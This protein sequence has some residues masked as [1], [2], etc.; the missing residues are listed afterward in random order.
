[1]RQRFEQQ[2]TIGITP[3]SEVKISTKS[4]DELPPVL[5][6]LQYI[7]ATP[8]LNESIFNLL[9]DKVCSGKKKTGRPGMDLWH[10]LV[11][12]VVRHATGTNWDKLEDWSNNHTSL[13]KILGVHVE[14]FGIEEMEFNYQTI[15]DNVGM[16]D[17]ELLQ[18]INTL[19]ATHGQDLLKKKDEGPFFELKTDSFVVE[20]DVHFPT[21]LHLLWDS[22][23]KGLDMVE[24]LQKIAPIEG[25][26]E[27]KA[28]RKKLKSSF[29][30]T[31]Q[32]VFKGKDA[33]KKKEAVKGYLSMA[34][35]LKERCQAIIK[36]PP[37]N[38]GVSKIV[39]FLKT[40]CDYAEKF[41]D[42]IERRLIKGE[43]IPADE[44][45]FSIFEPYTEWLTKGKLHKEVEL[46]LLVMIT[47]TQN[48][49]IIDYK[50][51][52]K[53]RDQAQVAPLL[54]RIKESYPGVPIHSHSFDKG[55]YSKDNL[56][57]LKKEV[58]V[59][60]MPKKG[61]LNKEEKVREGDETF[62]LLRNKH[63][64]VES[65]INMLEHHGLNRCLD[66]GIKGFKR[67]VGLSILAYNLHILGN[68]LKG[69][70]KKKQHDLALQRKRYLQK[71]A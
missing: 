44:K 26:R 11:L 12:A 69:E 33:N 59:P 8:A 38:A 7:F 28:W 17:E 68:Y 57:I 3:I 52:E 15:C 61:K 45:V 46:G 51:M 37:L 62:K 9:E 24:K 22:M 30:N 41:C 39:E 23:Y 60:V 58:E 25:W 31:S 35:E 2:S 43:V 56:T 40:Y 6:A 63:S 21:D 13:R 20:T 48:N 16:I 49:F 34:L 70:E 27:L 55:F 42:Q 53:Q 71:A 65:N 4:R 10:I 5:M 54:E 50:V 14:K 18:K 67:Y 64:A 66:K 19:V 47:T 1:M 36:N 29:R 32:A